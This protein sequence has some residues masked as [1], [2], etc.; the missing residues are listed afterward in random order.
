MA[1]KKGIKLKY[2]ISFLVILTAFCTT[3]VIWY[4]SFHALKQTLTDQYLE[5]NYLYAQKTA[6]S[7]SVLLNNMQQNTTS[8]AYILGK[9]EFKQEEIDE[10]R[11]TYSS[12]FNSIFI[13]NS[14]G[15]LQFVSPLDQKSKVQPGTKITSDLM[16]QALKNQERFISEPYLAQSGHLIL[17]ISSPIFDENGH[18][19]GVVDGTVH[20]DCDGSLENILNEHKFLDGSSVSVV[21]QS[22]KIIY[23]P[24]SNQIN[25]FPRDH[26][27]VK[28]IT[29][30][31]LG[32]S[33]IINSNGIEYFAAYAVVE[34]TGWGIV[35]KTPTSVI[36]A[37]LQD[38]TK[39]IIFQ[40][41]PILLLIL[42]FVWFLTDKLS[43]PLNSLAKFSEEAVNKKRALTL[44]SDDLEMKSHIYEIHQLYRHLSNYLVLLNNQ[45]KRDGLT[46]LY[47]RR[48]FN[49]VMKEWFDNHIQFSIIL[50]D[51][52]HFKKVN[53]TFGHQVG[54]DVLRHLSSMMQETC[55]DED[56]C[57]RYGG[58]E[59]AILT[60]VQS[61]HDAFKIA[62]RLRIRFSQEPN[63]IG[64]PITISFGISSYQ[65]E[66]L[67]WDEM[68]KRADSAL[69]QSKMN[70]RNQTTIYEEGN[71]I[72]E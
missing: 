24:N 22:G 70:G 42:V 71:S 53:D 69:Y 41:L 29:E 2:A 19:K 52:D 9:H 58:E 50:L 48:T 34:Q 36:E 55:R 68:V 62:E 37:P 43:K 28:S 23:H 20:L 54:D 12:Y 61:D 72:A 27:V 14:D 4:T 8:L 10:W 30:G 3:T 21:D 59:F 65:S 56:L 66:D 64:R 6:L 26:P 7:T 16:K 63:P 5:S 45:I 18:Y 47:N 49:Y 67:S 51:I 39:K 11:K 1:Y 35:I 44:P 40:S 31:K 33:K 60:T 57:F 17:L 38:L 32:S 15:V 25:D 13:A 46:G